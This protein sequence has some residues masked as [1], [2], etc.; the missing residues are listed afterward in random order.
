MAAYSVD[1]RQKIIDLYYEGETSQRELARIFNVSKSFIQKL[2]K[3]YR[4]T[5]IVGAKERTEQTPRKL[6]D[7][8]LEILTEIVEEKN[9]RTLQEIAD[10]LK[11]RIGKVVS[12]STIYRM[13]KSLGVTRKKK[14]LNAT[15]AGTQKVKEERE[16]FWEE[17]KNIWAKDMI[18][19]DE[20]GV[21]LA[22]VRLYGRSKK[23]ERARGERPQ[24]RGKNV[25]IISAISLDGVIAE[26]V[27][28]GGTDAITFEAFISQKVLPNL[29]AGKSVLMDNC[30]IHKGEAIRQMIESVGAELIYL[31]TYSPEYN[32]IE[33][34]WS[35]IKSILQG[36]SARTYADLAIAIEVAFAKVSLNDIHNWFTHSYSCTSLE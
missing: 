1:L 18:F 13:L 26:S 15:E 3:Q 25:S 32:P 9:D 21:N 36:L 7:E 27:L 20:S 29:S 8:E 24:K 33:Q 17:I 34:M 23:G 5:G 19:L 10:Q 35:K 11:R 12:I 14:A 28:L 16:K 22:M 6:A 2:L 4:E 30:S 31:P